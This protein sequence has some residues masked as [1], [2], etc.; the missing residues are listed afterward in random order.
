M[1]K[2][3]A[4][5][6]HIPV[7]LE[8][9]IDYL[10]TDIN[11]TYIDGT[12]GRG[13][14]SDLILNKLGKNGSLFAFDKDP[15]AEKN[16][17]KKHL[18]DIRFNFIRAGFE[19]INDKKNNEKYNSNLIGILV[20]LGISSPQIDNACRG[21][22]FQKDG[23]LDMRF[24]NTQGKSAFDVL[25][26]YS[27]EQLIKIFKEY[28]EVE[29]PRRI[30]EKIILHREKSQIRTTKELSNILSTNRLKLKI[31]PA[32]KV[33]QALRIEVNDELNNLT[34]FLKEALEIVSIGGRICVISFHSLEDRIVK[35]FIS[36]HSTINKELLQLRELP[37]NFQPKVKKV[38][39]LIRPSDIEIKSN[40]RSRSA[41][42]RVFEKVA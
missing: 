37:K 20:D 4:S 36:E 29:S 10:V 14:H 8:E 41:R 28:G 26:Y 27:I 23:E 39:N 12:Y 13:G 5:N 16:I 22:S 7:L 21:F 31:H 30:A 1:T 11:G 2:V 42:L 9:S 3:K 15:D 18:S 25:N 6:Q 34:K 38:S 24:D 35:K 32:T 17:Q 33:F 40:P 19:N